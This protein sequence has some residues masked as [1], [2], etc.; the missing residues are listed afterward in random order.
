MAVNIFEVA[1]LLSEL[2]PAQQKAAMTVDGR[3]LVIAGAGSGKTKTLTTRIAYMMSQGVKGG[4]IFC[5][6]FT[7]K[8]SGEMKERLA[9]VV[10]QDEADKV[11]M[12]TFHSLCV[13]ILRRDADKLGY[14]K[15]DGRCNFVIYDG[16][17]SHKLLER[18]FKIMNIQDIKIGYASNYIDRAKNNLMDPNHCLLHVAET[19]LD[20]ILAQVY[21]RYQDMMLAANAMDFGDLIM[22]VVTL[23][24]EHP[25]VAEYWQSKFKYVMSDEYQDANHA[26]FRLLT[27]LAAPQMNVFV[28]GDDFQSIY[29]FRGSDIGIIL[30]FQRHFD[31]CEVIKLE[32]NYRSTQT[33][34]NAGDALIKHNNNQMDKSLF[35]QKEMGEKIRVV[36]LQNEYA[37]AA[38][39]AARIKQLIMEKDYSYG[40]FAIL[41]RNSYQSQA[42]EQIFKNALIPYKIIG[43]NAF[44]ERE[45]IKDIASYLRIIANRKD[46]AAMLRVMNKPARGIGKTSQDA[47]EKY[48][49]DFKVS[50]FRALKNVEDIATVKKNSRGKITTFIQTLDHLEDRQKKMVSLSAFVRYVMDHT[51]LMKM[52]RERAEKDPAEIERLENLEEFVRMVGHYEEQNPDKTLEEFMQEM[53]LLSDNKNEKEESPNQI[54]LLT[55]HA[56]KGLEFPVVFLPGWNENVFPGWRA[57]TP[58]DVEEERRLGYVAVTRAEKELEITYLKERQRPNGKGTEILNPSR[59]IEELPEEL[60]TKTMM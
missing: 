52:Y 58:D 30:S 35:S 43:G 33:I 17:D 47:I 1:Q 55:I 39:T 12:G 28:V 5:A 42:F 41:Y 14:E 25:D 32:Q 40:D 13:R 8:A 48:S 44:F 23:L 50:V 6:T 21:S 15:K 26:Q 29:K 53:S 60:V 11:W 57:T 16:Y 45:E 18:V 9:K 3:Y 49:N 7:N 27:N 24:E 20:Q 54:R 46:D 59:F 51:G 37:E 2:N 22:N 31:P 10:G 38:Y 56:S 19:E 4:E 34:V 36:G